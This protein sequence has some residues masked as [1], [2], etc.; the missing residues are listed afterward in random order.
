[1]SDAAGL[2]SWSSAPTLI[3]TWNIIGNAGTTAGTNFIGT[4]DNQ[5]L[6]FKTNSTENMRILTSGNVGI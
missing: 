5:P 4:T 6:V 3:N 2:A 1:M